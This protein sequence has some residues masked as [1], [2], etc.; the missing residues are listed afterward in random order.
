MIG[1]VSEHNS[2]QDSEI[3]HALRRQR[4]CRHDLQS[5]SS[6]FFSAYLPVM[7]ANLVLERRHCVIIFLAKSAVYAFTIVFTIKIMLFV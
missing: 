4:H 6:R 2:T 5:R 7:M 1:V 3:E